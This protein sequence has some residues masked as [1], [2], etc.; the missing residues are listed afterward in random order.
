MTSEAGFQSADTIVRINGQPILSV[1]DIQWVL[2]GIPSVVGKLRAEI[3]RDGKSQ[4]LTVPLAS[5]WRNLDD[6]SRR[7]SAWGLRRMVTGGLVFETASSEER[8]EAGIASERML[9]KVKH[10]GLYGTHAAGKM[11][12]F[13]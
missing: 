2:N 8:T 12:D 9:L 4:P 10:V 3:D 13:R 7:V 5:G 1:A 6:I 11:Q